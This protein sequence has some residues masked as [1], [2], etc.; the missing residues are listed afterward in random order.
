MS[1]LLKRSGERSGEQP[2]KGDEKGD[3]TMMKHAEK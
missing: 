2:E 1:V 3:Q